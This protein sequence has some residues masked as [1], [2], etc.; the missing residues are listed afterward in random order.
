VIVKFKKL[1]EDAIIPT[2]GHDDDLNAGIDF[3]SPTDAFIAKGEAKNIDLQIAWEPGKPSYTKIESQG[4]PYSICANLHS[5]IVE[6]SMPGWKPA[7]IIKGRSGLSVNNGIECCNA[8]V[9][10]SSYRGS[11]TVRLYNASPFHYDVHKGDRIAQGVIILVPVVEI[12]EA[13]ELS[14]S[15]RGDKGLGSSG[16]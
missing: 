9:I 3:Y 2:W 7:M 10:D 13:S 6:K 8:G 4:S 16:R 12:Q 15:T 5:V 14:E 1:S 11:I